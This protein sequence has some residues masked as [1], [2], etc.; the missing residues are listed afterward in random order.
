MTARLAKT[1]IKCCSTGLI[2]INRRKKKVISTTCGPLLS[3]LGTRENKDCV[4]GIRERAERISSG[5][6][7]EYTFLK[8]SSTQ[9]T[10]HLS[11]E[12]TTNKTRLPRFLSISPNIITSV[13]NARQPSSLSSELNSH[14]C[15]Q[16][17]AKKRNDSPV[18]P[19]S[20]PRSCP[21]IT[22][23]Q[24]DVIDQ[25]QQPSAL[26]S[27]DLCEVSGLRCDKS[28]KIRVANKKLKTSIIF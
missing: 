4:E 9:S 27:S 2:H 23:M 14:I 13:M 17:T 26:I 24:I 12:S 11:A 8:S 19:G 22:D 21:I 25:Q 18:P 1:T 20:V 15:N 3:P 28:R 7:T 10:I 5:A 16:P 6:G